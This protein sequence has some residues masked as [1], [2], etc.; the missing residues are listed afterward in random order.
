ML[1]VTKSKEILKPS[2]QTKQMKQTPH[3]HSSCL[4]MKKPLP[5]LQAVS[6]TDIARGRGFNM[7]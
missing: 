6:H 7:F 4:K 3:W 5:S 2:E 1:N